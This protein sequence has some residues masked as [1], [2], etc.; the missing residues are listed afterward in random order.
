MLLREDREGEVRMR[1]RQ[2]LVLADAL[3]EAHA[4]EA[5]RT[6]CRHRLHGLIADACASLQ[7]SY[8]VFTR[9]RRY[10]CQTIRPMS[11]PMP[12]KKSTLTCFQGMPTRKA[13]R[14]GTPKT[15]Q[16]VPYPA[17]ARR[18]RHEE[19]DP[20]RRRL[21]RSI[22]LSCFIITVKKRAAI[23]MPVSLAN[24]AGCTLK[25]AKESQRLAPL[26]TTPANRTRM[27]APTVTSSSTS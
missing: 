27:S 3:A 19:D 14:N 4:P 18:A 6:D 23:R 13:M 8:V 12:T 16:A 9:S 2:V 10:G 7:G 21:S 15:M 20:V 11:P 17:Q 1:L 5:A 25:P 24:S 22:F 26:T